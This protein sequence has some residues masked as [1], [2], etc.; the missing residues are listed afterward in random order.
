MWAWL[1]QTQQSWLKPCNPTGGVLAG[2]QTSPV[3]V[4]VVQEHVAHAPS[5]CC[6]YC[7]ADRPPPPLPKE[8][9]KPLTVTQPTHQQASQ[10]LP[11]SCR[12]SR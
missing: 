7:L 5:S 12:C 1:M 9:F 2:K 10:Q 4:G 3:L 6:R 8:G 11:S